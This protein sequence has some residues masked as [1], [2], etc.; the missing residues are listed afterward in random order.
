MEYRN[1]EL[2]AAWTG[3]QIKVPVIYV[4]Y[5]VGEK[6]VVY[7]TPG[8]KTY[9]HGSGF[10]KDVP[11]LQQVVVLEGVGHFLNQEKP[12]KINEIIVDFIKNF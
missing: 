5:V 6:D 2:T 9:I 11:L 12:E 7:T 4:I 1:W 8:A 10:K 3:I